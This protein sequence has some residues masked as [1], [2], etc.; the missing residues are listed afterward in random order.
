[1][2]TTQIFDYHVFCD[3]LSL[4]PFNKKKFIINTLNAYSYVVAKKDQEFKKSLQN[5][6]ILLPDGFPIV[7][8]AKVL[9]NKKIKKIAGAD[10]FYFLL[11]KANELGLRVF[12]LGSGNTILNM[13]KLKIAEKYPNVSVHTYSP[14]FKHKFSNHDNQ[15]M[16][17]MV[18][19][20]KPDVLF[21]GMT[22]PKQEKWVAENKDELEANIICS[23]GAVFDFYAGSKPRPASF[24]IKLNLE[25]LIRLLKEPKRMW[26]R[27]LIYS[28][29]FFVDLIYVKIFKKVFLN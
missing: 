15:I 14:P 5:A 17:D 23:I 4:I 8:A 3:K 29:I 28:P 25:W 13:I 1:M 27:Y 26:K 24:W 9:N 7:I 6:E 16:I 2:K 20:I 18:N 21:V 12:F 10:I 22:A 19:E 11:H